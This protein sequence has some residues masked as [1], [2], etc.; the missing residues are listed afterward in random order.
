MM[1][2]EMSGSMMRGTR[3]ILA[4]V[5]NICHQERQHQ[6]KETI[7]E[8]LPQGEVEVQVGG[9]HLQRLKSNKNRSRYPHRS[10]PPPVY[11]HR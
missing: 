11:P 2:K 6:E 10:H 8:I 5:E 3:K 9:H 4:L 1:R 7:K